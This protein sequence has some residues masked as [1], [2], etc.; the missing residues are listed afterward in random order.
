MQCSMGHIVVKL[1]PRGMFY[2]VY[3]CQN[4]VRLQH[5]SKSYAE[6]IIYLC[7]D[8]QPSAA[9]AF[10][11]FLIYFDI[12]LWKYFLQFSREKRCPMPLLLSH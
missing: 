6:L 2:F 4:I 11:L 5:E 3:I 9:I 12:C 8:I 10:N 7:S 1:L